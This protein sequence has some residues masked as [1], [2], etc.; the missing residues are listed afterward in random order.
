MISIILEAAAHLSV[1]ICE[2]RWT[3][4]VAFLIISA[5]IIGVFVVFGR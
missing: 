4:V 2:N 5:L 3:R 1:Q